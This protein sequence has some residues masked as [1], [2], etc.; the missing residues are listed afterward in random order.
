[1]TICYPTTFD[2]VIIEKDELDLS[3]LRRNSSNCS[4][5][6]LMA[7]VIFYFSQKSFIVN[8]NGKWNL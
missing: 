5:I 7:S 8:V 4:F 2:Y 3:L 6:D 1:M